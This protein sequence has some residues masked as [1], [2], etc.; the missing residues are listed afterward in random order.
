[1]AHE[2]NTV[3][4]TLRHG[5]GKVRPQHVTEALRNPCRYD[6]QTGIWS[7]GEGRTVP[8]PNDEFAASKLAGV[9]QGAT[10]LSSLSPELEAA[11]GDWPASYYLSAR[12]TSL[13]AISRRDLQERAGGRG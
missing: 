1:M 6:T 12:R 10:D 13:L 11:G 9:L 3:D 4:E 5:N 7:L 8:Y 2:F